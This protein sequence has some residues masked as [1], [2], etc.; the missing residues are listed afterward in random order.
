MARRIGIDRA[1]LLFEKAPIDRRGE[2]AERM[3]HIDDLVSR[4]RKRAFCPLSPDR[5]V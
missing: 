3:R 4:A 2:L 1:E 5:V